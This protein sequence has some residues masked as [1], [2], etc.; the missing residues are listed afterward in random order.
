MPVRAKLCCLGVVAWNAQGRDGK[1]RGR[2]NDETVQGGEEQGV[3]EE[4]VTKMKGGRDE[5]AI[6][7][8]FRNAFESRMLQKYSGGRRGAITSQR[9]RR[10]PG[11]SLGGWGGS[12]W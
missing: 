6:E 10:T 7:M 5:D 12:R 11:V 4:G 9:R 8:Y 3:Y 2:F 1:A